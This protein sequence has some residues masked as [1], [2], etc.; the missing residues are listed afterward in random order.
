MRGVF[1]CKDLREVIQIYTSFIRSLFIK[2]VYFSGIFLNKIAQ[3]SR[4][5]VTAKFSLTSEL[6]TRFKSNNR[7]P[8]KS[9]TLVFP[10][11]RIAQLC[12][13]S[14]RERREKEWE[15]STQYNISNH[16]GTR[17]EW[18]CSPF[19]GSTENDSAS[20]PTRGIFCVM[21]Y[22]FFRVKE[23]RE[24]E[25]QLR[26]CSDV[27][28]DAG[29][30][31]CG[32]WE[33]RK[34]QH[35]RT[36][37]FDGVIFPSLPFFSSSYLCDWC[38]YAIEDSDGESG[39]NW[40]AVFV[41]SF[42]RI[43]GGLWEWNGKNFHRKF[44]VVTCYLGKGIVTRWT[45]RLTSNMRF[46]VKESMNFWHFAR[47]K[48]ETFSSKNMR[49]WFPIEFWPHQRFEQS[50]HFKFV[51]LNINHERSIDAVLFFWLSTLKVFFTRPFHLLLVNRILSFIPT[52]CPS[53]SRNLESFLERIV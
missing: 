47:A 4:N 33:K 53:M 24:N 13:S 11:L 50:N 26:S 51:T 18:R 16:S 8:D 28:C 52:P 7:L 20:R 39:W 41:F 2:F 19:D 34:T 42:R 27:V 12:H 1:L 23:G 6:S 37:A 3:K 36:S 9:V 5:I 49:W 15:N 44:D 10:P 21:L 45:L 35:R 25:T 30:I 17:N 43:L 22:I 40:F 48:L 29:W 46:L 32:D 38:T 14:E 31:K